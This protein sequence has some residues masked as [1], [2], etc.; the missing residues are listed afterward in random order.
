M[1][2]LVADDDELCCLLLRELLRSFGHE[3]VTVGDG[4]EAW[5]H[6]LDHGAD[7][8]ISDWQMPGLTGVELCQQVRAHPEI[9]YPYFILLTARGDRVDIL[10]SVRAGV[11]DHLAKP[12]DLGQLEARLIVA[13]RV[14]A[15]HLEIIQARQDM[16][17]ANLRLD[18]AAHRD[19]LTGLGNRLRL[20]EDLDSI[21]GRFARQG[22]VYNIA[23]LD[24]DHFKAYNDA[25]GHQAGDALLAETGA[26]LASG[27]RRGDLAYRYGGDEFLIVL[28]NQTV[29]EA[30]AAA[31]RIR[32]RVAAATALGHLPAA[33]TMSAGIAGAIV[34]ETIE[35]VIGRAD[36]ALYRAKDAGRD[37]L[38]V[39]LR[40]ESQP[41]LN[42]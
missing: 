9:A 2:V 8:V 10:T 14:R 4:T 13:E 24:I 42:H 5:R 33:A 30:A 34:G 35:S 11:D 12:L 21:H 39:D 36:R 6:L 19:S 29:H 16:A 3:C 23:L 37:R 22:H 28:P 40:H 15:L 31:E 7:V 25:Y 27:L 1:H 17:A 41:T 38:L 26:G 18:E 20:E 32:N